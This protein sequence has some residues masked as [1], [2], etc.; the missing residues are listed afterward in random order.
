MKN[1]TSTHF[2]LFLAFAVLL[3]SVAPCLAQGRPVNFPGARDMYAYG[4]NPGA[5]S[6]CDALTNSQGFI[7]SNGVFSTINVS[8]GYPAGIGHAFISPFPSD[9]GE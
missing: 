5:F 3:L 4:I 2:A 8:G 6:T 7:L 1:G 9:T